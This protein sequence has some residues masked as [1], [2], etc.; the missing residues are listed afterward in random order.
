MLIN[1]SGE[2]SKTKVLVDK[3]KKLISKGVSSSKILIILGT[4]KAKTEFLQEF[5]DCNDVKI[6]EKI[7]VNT[8]S[9]LVY[10]TIQENWGFLENNIPSNK[11][12]ILPNNSGMEPSQFILKNIINDLRFD[13]YNSKHSLLHQLFRRYSLIVQNNLSETDVNK[14]STILK[15][16]FGEDAATAMKAFASRTLSYRAFDYLRQI[17][18]FNFIYKKSDYFK[19]IEYILMDDADEM[20]PVCIDFIEHLAPQIKDFLIFFDERGS[21]RTGYLSADTSAGTKLAKI[22]NTKIETKGFKEDSDAETIYKN[23][24]S[25][26]EQILKNFSIYSYPKRAHMVDLAINKIKELLE[27]GVSPADIA[28]IT[29]IQDELL[30]FSINENLNSVNKIF[31]LADRC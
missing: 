18:I 25:E 6:I 10:N 2:E 28:I 17:Q 31:L 15:E 9:G 24:T 3:F 27:H 19:D 1:I 23:V 13:G 29:P 12:V 4:G 30:K 8:F 7:R 22:F 11:A 20:T 14:R 16:S 5:Y 26:T 21:S